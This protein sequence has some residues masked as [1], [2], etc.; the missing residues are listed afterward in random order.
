MVVFP[1]LGAN[2]SICNS[3]TE[4]FEDYYSIEN[5]IWIN[6]LYASLFLIFYLYFDSVI[7][8][9]SGIRKNCLF[10]ISWIWEKGKKN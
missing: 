10:F 6:A 2:L 9:E 8:N 1:K 4:D 7:P 3:C 5:A